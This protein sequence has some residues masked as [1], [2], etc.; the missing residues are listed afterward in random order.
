MAWLRGSRGS[1]GTST[2][3]DDSLLATAEWF[4]DGT[5]FTSDR[6]LTAALLQMAGT[7]AP[8]GIPRGLVIRAAGRRTMVRTSPASVEEAFHLLDEVL[9]ATIR[10]SCGGAGCAPG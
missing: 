7:H 8:D 4:G 6:L 5:A 2:S 9:G 10:P 1:R 3:E